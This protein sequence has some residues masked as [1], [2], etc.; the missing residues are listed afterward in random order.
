MDHTKLSDASLIALFR[1]ADP[2]DRDHRLLA[3]LYQRHQKSVV[4]NCYGYLKDWEAAQDVSQEVWI[5]VMSKLHQFRTGSDFTPW[6]SSIVHN[7]SCDHLRKDKRLLD[8]EI[9]KKIVD[10]LAEE[11]DT[12][13]VDKPLLEILEE[14]MEKISGEEKHLLSLKYERGWTSK[15]IAQ[16]LDISEDNAKKRISRARQKL[17]KLLTRYRKS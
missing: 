15:I 16:S 6:L 12:E 9:S 3:I 13:G 5:R 8:Q 4:H 1:Q 14:L 2:D 17:A 7:R 10:S 11:L